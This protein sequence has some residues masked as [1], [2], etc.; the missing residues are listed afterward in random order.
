MDS[1]ISSNTPETAEAAPDSSS[2]GGS[3]LGFLVKF[4]L[5]VL[6]I[7]SLLISTYNIPSESM[8]PRLLIG[9]YLI[10]SKFSYG[11]SRYS[12]PFNPPLPAG[13]VLGRLPERGDVVVFKAPPGNS[14]E[15]I[16]RVIGLPGDRIQVIDGIVFINDRAIP[17]RQI[18]DLVIPVTANMQA[19]SP[20]NPCFRD[21]F[22]AR[23]NGRLVCRYPQFVESLP[24]GRSY[25]VLDLMLGDADSTGIYEVPPGHVFLMGD[26]R[27]RSYDSRFPAVENQG[28]G[29]VPMDNIVAEA[30]FTAFSTDGSASWY[31]PLS[32]FSATRW[33]RIGEG[34]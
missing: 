20:G 13:R 4:A 11:W 34:F 19:A 26:N 29:I 10:A 22:E 14:Q 23:V 3:F 9:D 28:I 2:N 17:R 15:Y 7:R 16:K 1:T 27:D 31:N 21:N 25:R 12:W 18:A 33:A 24:N 6:L 32:W 8:Q 5:A 30:W